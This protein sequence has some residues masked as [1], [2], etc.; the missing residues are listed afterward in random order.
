MA[1]A[2]TPQRLTVLFDVTCAVCRRCRDWLAAQP[3]YVE[4]ELLAANSAEADARYGSIPWRGKELVV[5]DEAGHVWVGP[6]AFVM[7][8]WALRDWRQWSY[9][10]SSPAL[11]P[12][13]ERFF[14]NVSRQ[15]NAFSRGDQCTDG[16]CTTC[17][18]QRARGV[19][20]AHPA[21]E[22]APG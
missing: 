10:L 14:L 12:H 8:L 17:P 3:A 15:R 1:T 20:P 7:C 4:L 6:A 9:R 11:A 2:V 13:A 5:A 18:P 21:P 19:E 16:A 22:S